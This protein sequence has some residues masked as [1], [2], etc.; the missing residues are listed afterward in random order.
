MTNTGLF[1]IGVAVMIPASAG[2]L[3]LILAAI[4]D[5]RENDRRQEQARAEAARR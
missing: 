1:L 4:A 2:V 5:G 3:G